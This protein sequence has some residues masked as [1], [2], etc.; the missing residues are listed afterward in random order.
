[1]LKTQTIMS[2]RTLRFPLVAALTVAT[3]LTGCASP[4]WL[5]SA[6]ENQPGWLTPYRTDVGQGNYISQ[7]MADRL[8]KGMSRDQVRA[9]LGT[10]LLVDPFRANRWD[11]VFEIRRGDGRKERRRFWVIF[12]ND[13]LTSWDGDPL[14]TEGSGEILPARPG[15]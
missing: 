13:A 3:L 10:P 1:M 12:E 9:T 2:T 4:T 14:P 7:S 8:R 11:Y 15:R 5:K 6:T